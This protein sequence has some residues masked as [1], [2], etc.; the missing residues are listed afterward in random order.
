E[1]EGLIG[2][3]V[4]SLPLRT[5]VSSELSF[6][7]LVQRV[8]HTCL[9]AYAHQDLPFEKLVEELQ[10]GRSLE[11][12]PV[13][14][15]MFVLQNTPSS[16]APAAIPDP[17]WIGPVTQGV[18]AKFELTLGLIEAGEGLFG[19]IEYNEDLFDEPTIGAL[20][21]HYRTLLAGAAA[22][23]DRPI[24]QLSMLDA[25]E[26]ERL[27]A[28]G[29][30]D[31]AT[32]PASTAIAIFEA[33]MRAVPDRIAIARGGDRVRYGEL[34][35]RT[36]RLAYR[37]R[38]SGIGPEARVG[39][40]LRSSIEIVESI[41]AVW[42]AGAAFVSLDPDYPRDRLAFIAADAGLSLVVTRS[43]LRDGHPAGDVPVLSVDEPGEDAPIALPDPDP[44]RLAY[45]LYTSGSTGR[46]KG[47][48]IQQGM[49]ANLFAA[50][51]LLLDLTAD[52]RVLQFW[53]WSFDAS[54]WDLLAALGSGAT[55]CML[56]PEEALPGPPMTAAL[57]DHAV[58]TA[59]VLP[60]VLAT[61]DPAEL[62]AFTKVVSGAEVCPASEPP[63]WSGRRF[64]NAYGPTE[65][66]VCATAGRED[67][68]RRPAI[69]RPIANLRAY[70]LDR[71]LEMVPIGIPGELH[72]GGPGVARGYLGQP[73]QTAARFLPDPWSSEPGARMYRTGDRVR[74]LPD[75][76]LD[77][78]GRL[79]H[80]VKI[81]G[82]RIEPGEIAAAL[83]RHPRV[84]EA[85]VIA[86]G[87][88][89]AQRLAAYVVASEPLED[90][91]LRAHLL[92]QLPAYMMPHAFVMLDE[93]PRMPNGKLS[94]DRLPAVTEQ[95]PELDIGF[96]EPRT[97]VEAALVEL[98]QD[99]LQVR[100]VGIHDSFF[101]LGGHSLQA[102]QIVSRLASMFG[103]SVP[104]RAM[105]ETPTIAAL[106]A[107]LPDDPARD[108]REAAIPRV[109][110]LGEAI[111]IA[112]LSDDEVNRMLDT[113]SQGEHR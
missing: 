29:R 90:G 11:H 93:L 13:F 99:V 86:H 108:A 23:P 17:D 26:R 64:F 98:W 14:Q 79:D 66:T 92:R 71:N 48:M 52:E 20:I 60:S 81:R 43:D 21:R 104:L 25:D 73:A 30:G 112:A 41:L 54:Q 28:F 61:L 9:G 85:E 65:V 6:R 109:G 95:R 44:D 37:L 82:Y 59:L 91:E 57:R 69:G 87:A 39:L 113:F 96:A 27:L 45:V 102:T 42:Q 40:Y 50:L 31:P 101:E 3:V 67:G 111:D 33:S 106:A 8:Q 32:P 10:P 51:R 62:P 103:A 7:S 94:V 12:N 35:Q 1:L 36:R 4:N 49:L 63:R 97:P 19:S 70:V 53:S 2:L 56:T 105:F 84:R 58:T 89:T 16:G 34:S 76:H 38:R 22:A 77:F 83:R 72:V 55:L 88:A 78:L 68:A 74:W 15:V 46:P 100:P 5:D 47:V 24:G 75:G 107:L 110:R 80:Q 18:L